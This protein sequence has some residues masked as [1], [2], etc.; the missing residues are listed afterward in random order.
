MFTYFITSLRIILPVTLL[1]ALFTGVYVARSEIQKGFQPERYEFV[2]GLLIEVSGMFVELIIIV[3]F[4]EYFANAA[5]RRLS[6]TAKD[7]LFHHYNQLFS[8]VLRDLNNI[9]QLRE[10]WERISGAKD[11]S[12]GQNLSKELG[13]HLEDLEKN[14]VSYN[15]HFPEI[16]TRLIHLLSPDDSLSLL[17][18]VE[19]IETFSGLDRNASVRVNIKGP[20]EYQRLYPQVLSLAACLALPLWE[21]EE[22][23]GFS[24]DILCE[25][26]TIPKKTIS[27]ASEKRPFSRLRFGNSSGNSKSLIGLFIET[28]YAESFLNEMVAWTNF[29]GSSALVAHGFCGEKANNLMRKCQS[30][31]KLRSIFSR[32]FLLWLQYITWLKAKS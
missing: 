22:R 13:N 18:V 20:E 23:F 28:S 3:L 29:T 16:T 30:A 26:L 7:H 6:K 14:L 15:A 5:Q 4:I 24:K 12:I 27:Y 11:T 8:P 19:P 17:R 25:R 10:Q 31:Q 21:F 32:I 2:I 9:L 1:A